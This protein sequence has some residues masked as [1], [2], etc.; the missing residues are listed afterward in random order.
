MKSK[1]Q[2]KLYV[3]MPRRLPAY[4]LV[5]DL[6]SQVTDTPSER[7]K[8]YGKIWTEL[9]DLESLSGAPAEFAWRRIQLL[10]QDLGWTYS[11]SY[12]PD[13]LAK[14]ILEIAYDV[15]FDDEA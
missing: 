1:A 10:W 8:M 3:D 15:E 13:V 6:M 9:G 14:K 4:E 5:V 7:L 11:T 2:L 12:N